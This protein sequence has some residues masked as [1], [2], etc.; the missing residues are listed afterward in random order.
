MGSEGIKIFT[1]ALFSHQW[2]VLEDYMHGEKE[3]RQ[4]E[5]I[6]ESDATVNAHF[7]RQNHILEKREKHIQ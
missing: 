3:A 1:G 5:T 2:E 7:R 6:K 4:E